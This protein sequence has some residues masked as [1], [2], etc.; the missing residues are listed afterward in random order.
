MWTYENVSREEF[1]MK[2]NDVE[3]VLVSLGAIPIK[4]KISQQSSI[5][6]E[7]VSETVVSKRAIYE[8]KGEYYRVDEVLFPQKPFIVIEWTDKIEYALK[9]AMEDTDPFPYDLSY[10]KIVEEVKLLLEI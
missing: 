5:L 9:N 4:C 7:Y 6:S 1:E 8:Y 3:S 10:K 2:K